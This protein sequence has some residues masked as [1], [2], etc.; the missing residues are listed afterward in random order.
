FEVPVYHLSG[1][2]FDLREAVD[3]N[4]IY[5][6]SYAKTLIPEAG[7]I[8]GFM[9]ALS[10]V[11]SD[12]YDLVMGLCGIGDIKGL[13][14][15]SK[16][17]IRIND[18]LVYRSGDDY[19]FAPA[20]EEDKGLWKKLDETGEIYVPE[21]DEMNSID[22][23]TVDN[24][25][26]FLRKYSDAKPGDVIT[27]GL[28]EQNMIWNNDK[29][30]YDY[31]VDPIKW[32]VL[33]ISGNELFLVCKDAIERLPYND[34]E[35][36]T[37]W[38][39][40]SLRKW[41]NN[42]FCETAFRDYEKELIRT[43]KLKNGKNP[44][45]GTLG[46]ED[47]F[48]KVF[49]LSIDEAND[50]A[51]LFDSDNSRICSASLELYTENE[52]YLATNHNRCRWW[53]RSCGES[54]DKASYVNE[55]GVVIDRGYEIECDRIGVRPAMV[56]NLYPEE[57]EGDPL[58]DLSSEAKGKDADISERTSSSDQYRNAK[59]GEYVAFGAI[60]QDSETDDG[61]E[62]IEWQ[63]LSNDGSEL[64]LISK[65]LLSCREYHDSESDVTWENCS[66]RKWLNNDFYNT[67]FNDSEKKLIKTTT[68]KNPS[69]PQYG[70][71]GGKD[72]SDKVYLLSLNELL[73]SIYGYSSDYDQK[74]LAGRS[75]PTWEA[76]HEGADRDKHNETAEGQEAGY[77]WLRTPGEH[78]YEVVTVNPNGKINIDGYYTYYLSASV[79]PVIRLKLK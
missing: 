1:I 79:R 21:Q 28:Y 69:N 25:R 41:L 19:Y 17:W 57:V 76:I 75:A 63:V 72:T 66:L 20:Y 60:E 49:L 54:L 50:P 34:K 67:A 39:D 77:W 24:Y 8:I 70:T 6:I 5:Y 13:N 10:F 29:D 48:D 55:A 58:I 51:Y 61:I 9:E 52:I 16:R 15:Y 71:P 7:K 31:F 38:K 23:D 26:K 44:E 2:E 78:G 27:F 33:A 42:D 3:V 59:A 53:L 68:L 40:C 36:K 11:T 32:K 12:P 22:W 56:I 4:R 18:T 45:Y 37:N 43:T 35:G 62:P 74:N 64:V 30:E 47:T 65:H 46:C 73:D 14:E